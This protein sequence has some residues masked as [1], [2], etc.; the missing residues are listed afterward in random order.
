[1]W[2]LLSLLTFTIA[3]KDC[4]HKLPNLSQGTVRLST[5]SITKFKHSNDFFVLGISDSSC[6]TCCYSELLLYN[7]GK[8][9]PSIPIARVDA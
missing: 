7:Y 9:N 5:K 6:D 8:E 1:M 2:A 3:N 4:H